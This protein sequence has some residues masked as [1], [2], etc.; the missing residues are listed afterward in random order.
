MSNF[1]TMLSFYPEKTL[2]KLDF[3]FII[4]ELMNRCSG[5]LGRN[6]VEKQYFITDVEVLKEALFYTREMKDILE[7]DVALPHSGFNE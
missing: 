6:L 2:Q 4:Q 3:P 5:S 7:N 1:A